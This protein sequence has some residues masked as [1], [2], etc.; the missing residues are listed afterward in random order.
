MGS[1]LLLSRGDTML[2][3]LYTNN[4]D[5][6]YI[7]KNLTILNQDMTCELK[8]DTDLIRPTL[9]F[10]YSHVPYCNYIWLSELARYYFVK[11]RTYSQGRVYLECEEDY[12]CSWKA[13]L[14][15]QNVILKRNENIFNQKQEDDKWCV[16]GYTAVRTINFPSGF[17]ENTQEFVLGVAGGGGNS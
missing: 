16:Y 14:L 11:N 17:N 12:I 15:A 4:S 5:K 6:R 10:D 9:I 7:N 2:A 1:P 3:W 13:S 8:D